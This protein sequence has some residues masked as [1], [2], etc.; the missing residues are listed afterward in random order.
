MIRLF[1]KYAGYTIIEYIR[2]KKIEYAADL[3]SHSDKKILEIAS[4]LG[5]GGFSHFN[6]LFKRYTGIPPTQY[7][8]A[9]PKN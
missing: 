4:M 5:Y 2:M 9:N 1:K 7:R 6:H 3:L 8:K